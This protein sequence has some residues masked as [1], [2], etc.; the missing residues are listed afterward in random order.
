MT[1]VPTVIFVDDEDDV[2]A[3]LAALMRIEGYRVLEA[4]NTHEALR[5]LAREHVDVLLTDIVMPEAD[6]I[7]LA[8]RARQMQPHIRVLFATGYLARAVTADKLGTVL[9]KPVRLKDILGALDE[10]MHALAGQSSRNVA[11]MLGKAD[12]SA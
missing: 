10:V 4:R 1:Q 5:V 3:P 6:G 12:K 11:P 2:R 7:E 9:F 8:E